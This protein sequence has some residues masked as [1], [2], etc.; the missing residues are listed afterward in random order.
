MIAHK[1]RA[2]LTNRL[3]G[4]SVKADVNLKKY[5]DCVVFSFVKSKVAIPQAELYQLIFTISNPAQQTE[6]M[7]VKR[8]E[9]RPYARKHTVRA[10]KDIKAGELINVHCE[11]NVPL[12][13]EESLKKEFI[14][15]GK[16]IHESHLPIVMHIG[17]KSKVQYNVNIISLSSDLQEVK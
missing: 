12:L 9:V 7:P 11:I 10:T 4:I 8:E 16:E 3:N 5:E 13:L 15:K 17:E 1:A 6:M 14:E 2:I